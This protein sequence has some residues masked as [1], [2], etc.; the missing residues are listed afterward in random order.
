MNTSHFPPDFLEHYLAVAGHLDAQECPQCE[1]A[2][3]LLQGGAEIQ[4]ALRL[5]AALTG[6][7]PTP[8]EP[9]DDR[10]RGP[11]PSIAGYE[12]LEVLGNGTMGVVYR[13]RQVGL[14]RVVALKMILH[15][16]HADAEQRHR[17]RAEAEA[18]ARLQHPHV[19]QIHEIGEAGGLPFFSLEY[20]A[21]GSLEKKLTGVPWE[22]RP[23][24]ELVEKLARAVHA[25][26]QAQVVHRDLKPANVL[27]TADGTPKVTD[28]G[29]ARR[30]DAQMQTQSG[31][32]VGTP[33][34]MAPE[35]AAGKKDV[36]PPADVWA[37][38][39][40]LYELLAGRPPFRSATPLDTVLQVLSAE[41]A[42]LRRLRPKLP[43]DLETVC[44]KCLRKEPSRRYAGAG[45]LADDL[46][47]FLD[48]LPVRARPVGV[49]ER[50]AR[51]ARRRPA[52]AALSALLL[53]VA[54]AGLAGIGVFYREGAQYRDRARD[55]LAVAESRQ[56]AADALDQLPV[57][58]EL[59][60]LLAIEAGR[61]HRTPQAEDALRQALLGFHTRAILRPGEQSSVEDAAFDPQGRYVV[62]A[63]SDGSATLYDAA[64][65]TK[66]ASLLANPGRS[67]KSAQFSP[68][69]RLVVTAGA[70]GVARVWEAAS[71]K[72]VKEFRTERTLFRAVFSPSGKLAAT[73]GADGVARIWDVETQ[74]QLRA[75]SASGS[76]L[77]S[78]A[79]GPDDGRI[80]AA[81]EDGAAWV[82]D[83]RESP[84]APR[85][86]RGGPGPVYAAAFSPDGRRVV[87]AHW[88]GAARVWELA[89]PGEPPILL[90]GHTER[91]TDASFSRDG[92][93]LVTASRDGA[94]RVWDAQGEAVAVLR[95]H[96]DVVYSAAFDRDGRTVVTASAD[97]TAR[98]WQARPERVR[99]S[100][101]PGEE[102]EAAAYS[103]DGR[104]V[105][106]AS[107]EDA[108]RLWKADGGEPVGPVI[109]HE[110][111]LYSAAFGPGGLI[112]TAGADATARVWKQPSE[113]GKPL[114]TLSEHRGAV[115]RARFSPDGRLAV[116]AG[117]DGA[118]K[119]WDWEEE[120]C[121]A[122]LQ[123]P[124]GGVFDA[125]FSPDGGLVVA[126][127]RDTAARI[128]D[129]KA[130]PPR[131]LAE[132]RGHTSRVCGAAFS[133]DGRL[134][135]TA[136][137]DRT[138][139]VWEWETAAQASPVELHGHARLV[140]GADF[141]P[142]DARFAVT[143]SDDGTARVWDVRLGRTLA[144]LRGHGD[145]PLCSA[146][147]SPD[148][149]SVLTAAK[150]GTVQIHA[151]EE[152]APLEDLLR[153]AQERLNRLPRNLTPAERRKYLPGGLP[154]Q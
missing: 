115:R 4:A 117:E 6:T 87:T 116:T 81:S 151:F 83:W 152:A 45:E 72:C 131:C 102:L 126:A 88:D 25:A 47:R 137:D 120:K 73:A 29:L 119:V 97:G 34:Y 149:R 143:A 54:A 46:R 59:S 70:D 53:A 75:L 148:G 145:S 134:V 95:G 150:D 7:A 20:C 98:L 109:R 92:R 18:A 39:A 80:V 43:R 125:A 13:A 60:V 30:L 71:G 133:P 101:P 74:K 9:A 15:A 154:N 130:S 93:F 85:A 24:A 118:V 139:R 49:L 94:A 35:Q 21:G 44:L 32:V 52:V 100:L 56:L 2:L 63:N 57:D 96:K 86:L 110:G 99:F 105:L 58:P 5:E 3:R 11:L 16:D 128:W 17:F 124:R 31:A 147:F 55:L 12:V 41:P 37:L 69:G 108:V 91:V 103:P 114:H 107:R 8:R 121:L 79:F 89:A 1:E 140:S 23:A 67:V 14:G 106:T 84:N 48:G 136:S 33:A 129:W 122:T 111:R 141:H 104:L 51:W 142:A 90:R 22:A 64:A 68:D 153:L 65:G 62:T 127:G 113:T 66:G 28:F 26:H 123:G 61:I 10:G 138:A 38:G 146:V 144:V 135:L 50:A 78:A 112:L 132:L 76:R 19:V 82:W 36:G 77:F 42:A 40:I 27:L